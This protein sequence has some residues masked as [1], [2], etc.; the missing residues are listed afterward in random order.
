MIRSLTNSCLKLELWFAFGK[1]L[2]NALQPI[3]IELEIKHR[4]Y[5]PTFDQICTPFLDMALVLQGVTDR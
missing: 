4:G 2:V 5:N 3:K 1:Y